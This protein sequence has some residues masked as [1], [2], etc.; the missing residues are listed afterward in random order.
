MDGRADRF[1]EY[2]SI[3]SVRL[4]KIVETGLVRG[5]F[6]HVQ[7]GEGF[8]SSQSVVMCER[9]DGCNPNTKIPFEVNRGKVNIHGSIMV[10]QA[11]RPCAS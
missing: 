11:I 5:L 6:T 9:S 3:S 1:Q 2:L 8:L 4:L 10:D 7:N